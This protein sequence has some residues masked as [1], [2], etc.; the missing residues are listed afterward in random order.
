ML[1][2][3]FGRL[4]DLKFQQALAYRVRHYSLTQKIVVNDDSIDKAQK[5]RS[6]TIL[7][8]KQN[9]N[10][11]FDY[12]HGAQVEGFILVLYNGGVKLGLKNIHD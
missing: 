7:L 1:Y 5:Q 2:Q 4:I 10:E 9:S 3:N 6:M 11:I 8:E 12:L